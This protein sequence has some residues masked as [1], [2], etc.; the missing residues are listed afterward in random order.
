MWTEWTGEAVPHQYSRV[1]VGSYWEFRCIG[2]VESLGKPLPVLLQTQRFCHHNFGGKPGMALPPATQFAPKLGRTGVL[3]FSAPGELKVCLHAS[4]IYSYSVIRHFIFNRLICFF[5]AWGDLL[6]TTEIVN[7]KPVLL[8]SCS[9]PVVYLV[10]YITED[11]KSW[12]SK[13]SDTII[14]QDIYPD[15]NMHNGN[16]L[17]C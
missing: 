7:G 8:P 5:G 14:A 17:E 6:D 12:G 13:F 11:S 1:T 3:H 16:T 10:T 4:M 2:A 9:E 15:I